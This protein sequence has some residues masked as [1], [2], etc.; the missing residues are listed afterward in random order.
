MDTNAPRSVTEPSLPTTTPAPQK[1]WVRIIAPGIDAR[2]ELDRE[3]IEGLVDFALK[4][5]SKP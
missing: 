3:T 1:Q 2:M 4:L 5:A